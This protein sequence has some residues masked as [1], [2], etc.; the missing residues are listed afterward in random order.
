MFPD[1]R[2]ADRPASSLYRAGVRIL[3]KAELS[4]ARIHDFRR[5]FAS[6]GVCC[7]QGSVLMSKLLGHEHVVTTNRYRTFPM[8]PFRRPRIALVGVLQGL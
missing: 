4:D 6:M 1:R 3:A 7:G 8:I 5:S 2:H